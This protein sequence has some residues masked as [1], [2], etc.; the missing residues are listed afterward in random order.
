M[1]AAGTK[2]APASPVLRAESGFRNFAR[3]LLVLGSCPKMHG[4]KMVAPQLDI[5]AAKLNP[6]KFFK[7]PQD[8][9]VHPNLNRQAKLDILHQWEVDA[10]LMSVAEEENMGSGESSRLGAIVSALL[11][12]EDEAKDKHADQTGTPTKMGTITH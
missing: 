10:R 3:T 5:N 9:L 6:S 7:N 2:P 8:V 12:L 1:A 11:A 4:E